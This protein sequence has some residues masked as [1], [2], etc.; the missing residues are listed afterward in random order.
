VMMM[1]IVVGRG[2]L[3]VTGGLHESSL[4]L[5]RRSRI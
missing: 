5:A 4:R 2:V 3:G 1:I